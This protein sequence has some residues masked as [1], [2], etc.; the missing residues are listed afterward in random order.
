MKIRQAVE[1]D[2]QTLYDLN[3]VAQR[4]TQRRQLIDN[5]IRDRSCYLALLQ[6]EIVG[7]GIF[8]YSFYHCGFIE[9]LYIGTQHRRSGAGAALIKHIELLCETPKLFTSTNRSNLPM[10]ALLQKLDYTV[11][12]T[13]ENLDENDPEIVYFKYLSM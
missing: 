4:Q 9:M 12:G 10:Q 11:S 1:Q 8:N 6:D 13:I 3:E 2:K 5:S 7:Y